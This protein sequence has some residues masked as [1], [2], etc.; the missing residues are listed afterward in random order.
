MGVA[1]M[2][3]SR[4]RGPAA[5]AKEATGPAAGFVTAAY[6]A[7]GSLFSTTAW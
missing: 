4:S 7:R 1:P 6:R 2:P 3:E 5:S